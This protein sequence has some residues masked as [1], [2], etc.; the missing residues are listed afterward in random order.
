VLEGDALVHLEGAEHR[1]GPRGVAG[2]LCGVPHAYM[3]A[4]E[5]AL[6]LALQTP[7]SHEVF[8]RESEHAPPVVIGPA[9]QDLMPG[10][11]PC[12]LQ[13][14]MWV[15]GYSPPCGEPLS[16]LLFTRTFTP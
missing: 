11:S 13:G 15:S 12:W 9:A 16:R 2:A 7:G 14:S 10:A 8:Y 3:V 6:T 4:S 1:P 5:S